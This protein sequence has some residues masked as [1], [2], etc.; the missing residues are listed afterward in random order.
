MDES[1]ALMALV[2]TLDAIDDGSRPAR[3]LFAKLRRIAHTQDTGLVVRAVRL[4]VESRIA[5]RV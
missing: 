5:G 3:E 2:Q 1:F 4:H